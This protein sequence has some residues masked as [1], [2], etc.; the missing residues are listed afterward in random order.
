M[1]ISYVAVADFSQYGTATP[2]YWRTITFTNC[3]VD[4]LLV[5]IGGSANYNSANSTA[6]EVVT[7][8]GSTSIWTQTSTTPEASVDCDNHA[9]WATVT[10]AGSITVRVNVRAGPFDEMGIVGWRFPVGE[11]TGTPAFTAVGGADWDGSL[12]VTVGTNDSTVLYAGFDWSAGDP[13]TDGEPAGATNHTTY[14][15]NNYYAVAARSWTGQAAGTRE[16]G[17]NK[18]G[19][20]DYSIIICV[21]QEAT[22]EPPGVTASELW[23]SDGNDFTQMES[24]KILYSNGSEWS[25]HYLYVSNGEEWT[26]VT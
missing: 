22:P 1:A 4:D 11:W 21:V 8:S 5:V 10:G 24:R 19:E 26:R 7:T 23:H 12:E 18:D 6:R 3:Q 14:Y 20:N 15:D 13:G 9:G 16:Y 25:Q 2:N 17:V